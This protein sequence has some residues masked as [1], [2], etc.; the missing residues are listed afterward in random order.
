MTISCY[1]QGMEQIKASM[2]KPYRHE[3][4]NCF[5][6]GIICHAIEDGWLLDTNK[7]KAYKLD[8]LVT[9]LYAVPTLKGKP[10]VLLIEQYGGG[11]YFLLTDR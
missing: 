6:F 9:D 5:V 10:K 8:Q 11:E 4:T 3:K 2:L 7:L 1:F